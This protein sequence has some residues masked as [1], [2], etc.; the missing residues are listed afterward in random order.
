MTREQLQKLK[1]IIREKDKTYKECADA[2]GISPAAFQ[3]KINNKSRFFI[4][5]LNTLGDFLGMSAED[6]GLVFLS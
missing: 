4:D 3:A 1:G 5:E 2:I 6:K